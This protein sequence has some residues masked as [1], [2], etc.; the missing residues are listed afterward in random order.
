MAEYAQQG[1]ATE[2]CWHSLKRGEGR[3]REAEEEHV[4]DHEVTKEPVVPPAT[5]VSIETQ[6]DPQ[7]ESEEPGSS[8]QRGE[9]ASSVGCQQREGTEEQK[10]DINADDIAPEKKPVTMEYYDQD[11]SGNQT[12]SILWRLRNC[13]KKD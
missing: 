7:P 1:F 8:H 12:D 6:T 5:K 2:D 3:R 11:I 9:P 4:R 13:F 10:K